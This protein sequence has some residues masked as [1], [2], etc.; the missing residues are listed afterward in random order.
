[1][2]EEIVLP[3]TKFDSIINAT[4]I[5]SN[6]KILIVIDDPKNMQYITVGELAGALKKILGL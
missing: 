3:F 6:T 5:D 2:S 4:N 1:M